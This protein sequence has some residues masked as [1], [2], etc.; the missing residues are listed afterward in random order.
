MEYHPLSI[1]SYVGLILSAFLLL[2]ASPAPQTPATRPGRQAVDLPSFGVRFAV[3]SEY[4]R[5]PELGFSQLARF[6]LNDARQLCGL[7]EFDLVPAQPAAQAA[8]KLAANRGGKVLPTAAKWG[9]LPVSVVEIPAPAGLKACRAYIV[10]GKKSQVIVSAAT[11]DAASL[12]AIETTLAGSFAFTDAVPASD[13]LTL[14]KRAIALF[15]SGYLISLPEPFRPDTEENKDRLFFGIRD[16]T[17]GQD[18]VTLQ[19]VLIP[20]PQQ[21]PLDQVTADIGVNLTQR[22]G[23]AKPLVFKPAGASPVVWVCEGFSVKQGEKTTFQR[24]ALFE[25][26]EGR[27]AQLVLGTTAANAKSRQAYLEMFDRVATS[28]RFS[29]AY[30][31]GAAAVKQGEPSRP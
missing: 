17:T 26:G 29:K 6:S 4:Q 2:G 7:I 28:I 25:F 13:D 30:T 14:R 19:V 11:M 3:P 21:R 23:L 10:T 20:N 12:K 16:W 15:G 8:Q 18:E 1:A 9:S 22:L 27:L 5:S 24:I 31:E